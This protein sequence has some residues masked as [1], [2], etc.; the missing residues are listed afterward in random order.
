[1]AGLVGPL[2]QWLLFAGVLLLVGCVAW[3]AIVVPGSLRAL[4]G[5]PD[6]T[7][8][9][10]M[11]RRAAGVGLVGTGLLLLAWAGRMAAMVADFRDPFV[12]LSEDLAFL[13]RDTFPGTVWLGQGVVLVGMVGAFALAR[14][15]ERPGVIPEGRGGPGWMAAGVGA[16][17]LTASLALTSHAMGV[18]DGRTLAVAADGVHGLAAGAWIGALF[19]ILHLSR[20]GDPSGRILA[21]QLRSFSPLAV[22]CV[23]LL[24]GAGVWLSWTHLSALSDLWSSAYGRL[25]SAKVGVAGIVFAA[26]LLNWR[27][28]LPSLDTPAGA[29]AVRRQAAFEVGVAL[30]VLLL[31]AFLTQTPKP[32]EFGG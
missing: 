12:P 24:V 21:A 7:G 27:R 31:T 23:T 17:A 20:R 1:M 16:L 15:H 25:L 30:L 10:T 28:G 2:S 8:L 6:R 9:G 19:L 4:D 13:I 14:G 26:G 22:V 5:A 29:R 32:G 11:A 3:R 18:Q